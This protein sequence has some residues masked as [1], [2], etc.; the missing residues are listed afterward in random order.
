MVD[1][2]EWKRQERQFID[3]FFQEKVPKAL[4]NEAASL[5]TEDTCIQYA[6]SF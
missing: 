3:R 1:R 2:E 4:G 6:K 5:C